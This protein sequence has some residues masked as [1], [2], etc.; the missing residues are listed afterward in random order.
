MALWK[1]GLPSKRNKKNEEK[2]FKKTGTHK[3]DG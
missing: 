2:K 3:Q 1:T